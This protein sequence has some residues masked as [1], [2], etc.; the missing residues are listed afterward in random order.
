M[1]ATSLRLTS[2]TADGGMAHY[3]RG[4]C[5]YAGKGRRTSET[6]YRKRHG[7]TPVRLAEI[8]RPPG[9]KMSSPEYAVLENEWRAAWPPQFNR[10]STWP[11][12]HDIV[13]HTRPRRA[14]ERQILNLVINGEDPDGI[15]WSVGRK[16]HV[17]YW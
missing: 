8:K 5:R 6:S 10:M 9:M 11:R 17:Y 2:S 13:F 4:R 16:P 14:E 7:L 15:A 12:W 3:K 1:A